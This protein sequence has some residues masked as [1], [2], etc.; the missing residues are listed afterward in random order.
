MTQIEM[1]LNISCKISI[2]WVTSPLP[3]GTYLETT[4]TSIEKR[5][6]GMFT[7]NLHLYMFTAELF[8]RSCNASSLNLWK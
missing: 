4:A 1:C 8:T 6:A 3:L 2:D 5:S 7:Y